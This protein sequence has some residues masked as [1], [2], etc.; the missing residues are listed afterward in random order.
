MRH[1]ALSIAVVCASVL[2]S[3]SAQSQDLRNVTLKFLQRHAVPCR[4]VVKVD[5]PHGMDEIAVCEDGREWA[6]FW[7]ENEIAFVHPQTRELYKWEP[8]VYGSRP[9]LYGT[10]PVRFHASEDSSPLR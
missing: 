8:D 4:S 3:C 7:L 9:Q 2:L 1:R 10:M 5:S 6:L